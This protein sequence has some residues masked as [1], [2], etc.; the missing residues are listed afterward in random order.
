MAT[1]D[2][3]FDGKTFPVPK[4]SV[5]ELLKQHQELFEG[6][7]YAVRSSVP[8]ADFEAFADS[9]KTQKKIPVTK[10]N[11]V[12]LWLLATEFGLSEVAAECATFSVPVDQFASLLQR[13]SELERKPS[14]SVSNQPSR[15]AEKIEWLDEGLEGLRLAFETLRRSIEGGPNSLKSGLEQQQATSKPSASPKP[16]QAPGSVELPLKEAKS[17]DGVIS[18]LTK[19]H[20]G[21]VQEKGIVTITSQSVYD[22]HYAL[23]NV[24]DLTSGVNPLRTKKPDF[25]F[26]LSLTRI[27]AQRRS[28]TSGFAG[29]SA[30][31]AS[32]RLTTQSRLGF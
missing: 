23:T 27:S 30:T 11:A 10:E 21:N 2:L 28:Q 22:P 15:F 20:G 19:K 14:S 13:V 4:P 18:Y 5:I 16:N 3:V 17:L 26:A 1:L 29:I 6:K 12:S 31:C 8:L 24:A 9:L 32:A 25:Q 7:T